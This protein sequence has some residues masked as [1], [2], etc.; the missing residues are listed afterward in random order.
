MVVTLGFGAN[1]TAETINFWIQKLKSIYKGDVER[2]KARM[3]AL[4]LVS[5]DGLRKRLGD[6]KCPVY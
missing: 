1:T 2:K 4:A 3:A 6:V 5:R